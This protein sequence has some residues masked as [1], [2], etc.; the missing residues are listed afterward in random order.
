MMGNNIK[1]Q[2]DAI[3]GFS[4]YFAAPEIFKKHISSDPFLADVYSL[5]MTFLNFMGVSVEKADNIIKVT[6]KFENKKTKRYPLLL[7]IVKQMVSLDPYNRKDMKEILNELDKLQ[8][9]PPNEESF[10][11]LYET[12]VKKTYLTD[13]PD[14]KYYETTEQFYKIGFLSTDKRNIISQLNQLISDGQDFFKENKFSQASENFETAL[15][16][17]EVEFGRKEDVFRL[18]S[19]FLLISYRKEKK[20]EKFQ[21]VL[22]QNI[23]NPSDL[24][25]YM[26]F[27]FVPQKTYDHIKNR[28]LSQKQKLIKNNLSRFHSADA[29]FKEYFDPNFVQPSLIK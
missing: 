22:S 16:W 1:I 28:I 8:K 6:K 19:F 25:K 17:Y 11:I 5:G 2:N 21:K 23:I 4:S 20:M 26:E 9:T 24:E 27:L 12:K 13:A 7:P 10:E 29:F 15:N 18:I 14:H 3:P